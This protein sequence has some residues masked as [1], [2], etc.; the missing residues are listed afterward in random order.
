LEACRPAA[1]RDLERIAALAREMQAELEAMRGGAVWAAREARPEPLV[2]GYAAP[3]DRDD[4]RLIVGTIDEVIVGFGAAQIEQLRDGTVLGVVTDLF[5]EPP[6]RAIGVGETIN[7][8]LI[9]F[10]RSQQCIGIDAWALPGHRATK[11]FFEES[12]FTA[13]AIIM[14]HRLARSDDEPADE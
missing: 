12:G 10:C 14:H 1:P 4:A 13:R 11:N 7:N 2:D 3:L 9:S 5:V 6:A 8:D